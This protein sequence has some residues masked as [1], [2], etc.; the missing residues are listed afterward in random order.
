MIITYCLSFSYKEKR[1]FLKL[2]LKENN[3]KEEHAENNNDLKDK[4]KTDE[5]MNNEEKDM[6]NSYLHDDDYKYINIKDLL[7]YDNFIDRE[8]LKKYKELNLCY[9]KMIMFYCNTFDY[10][11]DNVVI[12]IDTFLQT[13]KYMLKKLI[14]DKKN[15]VYIKYE[16]FYKIK[17]SSYSTD[18]INICD[19]ICD[20]EKNK[21]KYIMK[22]NHI[23]NFIN[24]LKKFNNENCYLIF[25]GVDQNIYTILKQNNLNR[26]YIFLNDINKI[27]L[28][29]INTHYHVIMCNYTKENIINL[30]KYYY[31]KEKNQYVQQNDE[32]NQEDYQERV[33]II[34]Q[35]KAT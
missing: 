27:N 32:I 3:R 29:K 25:Q 21:K 2:L 35:Y 15:F 1:K 33:K 4:N 16:Y 19:K 24:K 14:V 12:C 30:I 31:E 23:D 10:L 13:K 26:I 5:V 9:D 28:N 6:G 17:L 8:F 22:N 7:N 20:D 34:T 18:H 11:K